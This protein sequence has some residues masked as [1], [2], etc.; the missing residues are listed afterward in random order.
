[1]NISFYQNLEEFLKKDL[2]III[3]S[4]SILSFEKVIVDLFNNIELL[5]NKLII[6]VLSVK[7]YPKQIILKHFD[8][9]KYNID[10]LAT[11][12]MFGPDSGWKNRPM[13]Y[14]NIRI[15]NE[16]RA[17]L[18]LDIF[19]KELCKMIP[20]TCDIHDNYSAKSQFITHLT[21]RILN[22]LEL[23]TTPINT[24][25]YNSLLELFDN[26]CNDSFDLFSGL[27]QYND[28]TKMWLNKFRKALDNIE[29]KLND[30]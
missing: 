30:K 8:L 4:V 21:G 14:T 10:Y 6:D 2:D 19:R 26:T 7:K 20:L 23:E 18:F 29:N 3:I 12:P 28:E 24:N 16:N 13:V 11:H 27:Y 15:I 17:T 22:E 25:G 9:D 1:M 5:K